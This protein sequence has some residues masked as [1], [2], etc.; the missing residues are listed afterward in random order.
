[1]RLVIVVSRDE[2][3]RNYGQTHALAGLFRQHECHVLV[4]DRCKTKPVFDGLPESAVATLKTDDRPLL[5]EAADSG[6]IAGDN[7]AR[8]PDVHRRPRR[9]PLGIVFSDPQIAVADART[10]NDYLLQ[11]QRKITGRRP[12]RTRRPVQPPFNQRWR[13]ART[14]RVGRR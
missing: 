12:G 8:W 13:S 11:Q 14:Q 1:M 6:R 10:A 7:A 9:A 4:A 3:L 5:H 2:Y